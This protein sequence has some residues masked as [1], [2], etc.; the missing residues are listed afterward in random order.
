MALIWTSAAGAFEPANIEVTI[1]PSIAGHVIFTLSNPSDGGAAVPATWAGGRRLATDLFTVTD[2]AGRTLPYVG[3]LVEPSGDEEIVLAPGETRSFDID[4]AAA[5]PSRM[6]GLHRVLGPSDAQAEIWFDIPGECDEGCGEV[7][8]EEIVEPFEPFKGCKLQQTNRWN[9]EIVPWATLLATLSRTHLEG[10]TSDPLKLR[11]AFWFGSA[12][13]AIRAHDIMSEVET[14]LRNPESI[15]YSCG[16]CPAEWQSWATAF[17]MSGDSDRIYLCPLFWE[18]DT[19]ATKPEF[20]K[21]TGQSAILIHEITHFANV[22]GTTDV[23]GGYGYKGASKYAAAH[24]QSAYRNAENYEMH[25]Q[26]N[27]CLGCVP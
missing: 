27:P 13:S 23:S 2:P 6:S 9:S 21:T 16:Q 25:A 20:A 18:F 4:L 7:G 5:Y 19:Y 3:A 22:G 12:S 14:R 17:V 10:D 8:D 1:E 24:P 15:A 11:N 26:N